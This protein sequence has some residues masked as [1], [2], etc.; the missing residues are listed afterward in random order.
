M[1]NV[2]KIC[3]EMLGEGVQQVFLVSVSDFFH[4]PP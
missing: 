3:N 4:L 2:D 1:E